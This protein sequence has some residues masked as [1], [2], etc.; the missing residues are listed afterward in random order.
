MIRLS[1]AL[2][3]RETPGKK[4][5]F[6]VRE[7]LGNTGERMMKRLEGEVYFTERNQSMQGKWD[8]KDTSGLDSIEL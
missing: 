3:V 4:T 8:H 5:G 6:E 7:R 1:K 2:P